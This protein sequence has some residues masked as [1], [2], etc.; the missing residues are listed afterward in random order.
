MRKGGSK[1]KLGKKYIFDSVFYYIFLAPPF[2]KVDINDAFHFST[3][4]PKQSAVK[5]T[6]FSPDC[7]YCNCK[8]TT[9][10]IQEGSFRKCLNQV[11]R[12][13]FQAKLLQPEQLQNLPAQ[14]TILPK[15][16]PNDYIMFQQRQ[17]LTQQSQQSQQ[18]QEPKPQEASLPQ[19]FSQP[20]YDPQIKY[21]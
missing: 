5:G 12:K 17:F 14:P 21:K 7:I 8:N 4:M 6:R 2:L 11:C 19:Q 15:R 1:I 16:H 9:A 18:Q 10:L 20:N 13:Q 3:T